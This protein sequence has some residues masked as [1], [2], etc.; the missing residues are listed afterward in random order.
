VYTPIFD[1]LKEVVLHALDAAS[2]AVHQ[3]H[4]RSFV[5]VIGHVSILAWLHDLYVIEDS[6]NV[7]R[8]C[9]FAGVPRYINEKVNLSGVW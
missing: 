3:Q 1:V 8:K 7:G 5:E 6:L 4:R 2:R 9:G